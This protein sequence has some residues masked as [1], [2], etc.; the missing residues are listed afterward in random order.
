MGE[1]VLVHAGDEVQLGC[2]EREATFLELDGDRDL[3]RTSV[4]REMGDL[5]KTEGKGT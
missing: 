5:D 2:A 4:H 1:D 3:A